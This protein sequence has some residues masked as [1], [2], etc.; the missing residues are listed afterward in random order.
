MLNDQCETLND[1]YLKVKIPKAELTKLVY[2]LTELFE[3][4][5]DRHDL[6]IERESDAEVR[7]ALIESAVKEL[8]DTL[9]RLAASIRDNPSVMRKLCYG[10][11]DSNYET[12]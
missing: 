4:Q 7:A 12:D 10:S 1:R 3:D 9:D 2:E 6:L 8:T 11:S 5:M